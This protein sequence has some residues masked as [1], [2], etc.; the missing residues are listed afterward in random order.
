MKILVHICCAPCAMQVF[1]RLKEEF[2]EVMGLWYNPNIHPFREYQLRLDSVEKWVELSGV[3]VIYEGIYDIKSFLR[4]IV[5]RESQRC[6]FCYRM[7]LTKT[8]I[9]AKKGKFDY[10]AST[11]LS[12]P[13]QKPRLIQDVA[14]EVAEEY[15][16]KPYLK[17]IR[18]GWKQNQELSRKLGLYHQQYCGCVYSEE[19]RFKGKNYARE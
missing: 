16:I 12:S 3:K 14:K 5:Y 18:E 1:P 13:H 15:S 4:E 19:E 2:D 9:F 8:A 17:I 7:R 10:F 6:L 11:L